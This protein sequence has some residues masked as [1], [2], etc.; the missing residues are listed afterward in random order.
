MLVAVLGVGGVGGFF[1]AKLA[2]YYGSQKDV[3]IAFIAR[4]EH[5]RQIKNR[6]LEAVTVTGSFVAAPQIA[7]EDPE[8]IGIVDLLLFCVKTYDLEIGARMLEKN[9]GPQSTVLPLMNGVDNTARLTAILPDCKLLNGCAYVSSHIVMPG[10]VQQV[11]GPGQLL[12]GPEDGNTRPF[13]HIEKILKKAGINTELKSD[14]NDIVW[15]KYIFLSPMAA[16]TSLYGE[17]FGV[18]LE[19][20]ER[21]DLLEGLIQEVVRIAKGITV[22]E[23][24][25]EITLKRASSFPPKTKSS[26]QLD[27]EKGKRT[28]LESLIGYPMKTGEDLGVETPLYR[29]VYSELKRR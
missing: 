26:M 6:G 29:M 24:I 19:K 27:F 11:G 4:G 7:T 25:M 9:L 16:V 17:P 10:V 23:D 14:I 12:F 21:R 3:K 1:G 2:R 22:A 15:E 20:G 5:L 8:S 28:E 13:I 18:V